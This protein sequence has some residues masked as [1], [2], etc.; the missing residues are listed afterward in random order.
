MADHNYQQ[1]VK[2]NNQKQHDYANDTLEPRNRFCLTDLR[3]ISCFLKPKFNT[4]KKNS[5]KGWF[6]EKLDVYDYS[7]NDQ[8]T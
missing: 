1:I 8:L 6:Y 7:P 5:G 4:G 3:L 2:H